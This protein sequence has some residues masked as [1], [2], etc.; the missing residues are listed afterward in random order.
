ME[1][2]RAT[3]RE[4]TLTPDT[5]SGLTL[6]GA[7]RVRSIEAVE[8]VTNNNEDVDNVTYIAAVEDAALSE[9]Q[10]RYAARRRE[11]LK[12]SAHVHKLS[13][14][15][16]KPREESADAKKKENAPWEKRPSV[17]TSMRAW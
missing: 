2:W 17:G 10:A 9:W 7:D 5:W 12:D 11:L 14:A 15:A 6:A 16:R 1:S 4:S 3:Q 8:D 13:F